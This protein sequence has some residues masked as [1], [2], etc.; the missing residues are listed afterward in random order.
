M[1][2]AIVPFFWFTNIDVAILSAIVLVQNL[3]IAWYRID[4]EEFGGGVYE[5]YMGHEDDDDYEIR[6]REY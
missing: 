5:E 3:Y 6:Q 1:P 2:L 4:Q